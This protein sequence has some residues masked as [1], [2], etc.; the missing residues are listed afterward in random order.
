MKKN[1]FYLL[2]VLLMVLAISTSG[3]AQDTAMG[4]K[5]GEKAPDFT[6]KDIQTGENVKLYDLIGNKVIMLEFWAP[7]CNI[8]I[9]EMPELVHVYNENKVKGF[10]LLSI[11]LHSGDLKEVRDI[12]EDKKLNYPVLLDDKFVVATK[13]YRLAG[14]IPLK[15]IIDHNGIVRYAHVGDYPPN[16]NEVPYVLED[17]IAEMTAAEKGD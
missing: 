15:V 2:I 6:L 13:I 4:I 1:P 12:M 5:I 9:R 14:P 7:W 8:C 17:L 10:E 3:H 11:V 16:E